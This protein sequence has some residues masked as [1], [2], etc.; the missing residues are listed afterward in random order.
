MLVKSQI[1]VLHTIK[2]GDTGIVVQ[3]YSNTAGRCSLYFRAS[4]KKHNNASLLHKLNILDVVTY[5]NGPQ[6][7]PTIKEIGTPYNL[8][9]IRG[10]IFKSSIAIFM[11]ELLGKTVRESEAN[12]HLFSFI[13]SSIQILEHLTDGV[14]NFHIHFLT[15]LCKMLGFMPMDNYSSTTPLFDIATAKFTVQPSGNAVYGTQTIGERESQLLH[16][17]M[18]T[19]STNLGK[20]YCGTRELQIN[21]ELRLAYAKRMIEYI[22]HHIGNTIEIKSLDILHQIFS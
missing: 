6:S 11:S 3:C 2:H 5:S 21:G 9:T 1:V 7:M 10:D 8:S 14:A 19:P 12:P 4:S 15:H 20:L 22:S 18:N 17:L 16:S 13:S